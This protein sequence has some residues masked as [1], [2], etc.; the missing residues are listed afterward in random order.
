MKTYLNRNFLLTYGASFISLFGSKL[1]MMSYVAYI[2]AAKGSATLASIV[3][4]AD[5]ATSLVIGLFGTRYIDRCNAKHLLIGL[6][7]VA[8]V[9]TLSFLNFVSPD[10]YPFAIMVIVARA[11]LSHSVNSSRI[12]ALVQFFTKEETAAFSAVFNSSLF[13]A[14]ALAGAV[15]IYLLKFISF[16]T[17][18]YF[19][20]ATFLIAAGIFAFTRPNPQR[21]AE[22]LEASRG[23]VKAAYIAGAFRIIAGNTKLASAVF[24][25]ILSVTAFQ[26]TYEVLMTI[27]PQIWFG[28]GKSGTA[29]FFTCESVCVT[30]G[31]FL[32]QYL[33]NRG[34]ITEANQR[35]RNM[36]VVGVSALVYL[37]IPHL[38]HNVYLC[39]I[40][41][42]VMVVTVELIWTHQFKQMI[43]NIP[44]AKVAAVT[45]LQMAIGYSL[46]GVFAFV[47]SLGIDHLGV[48][49]AVYLNLLFGAV[50]VGGWE[51]LM[52]A[53]SAATDVEAGALA[54]E[55]A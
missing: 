14:A 13:M 42:N 47:F 49:S 46:M 8:A 5:W 35:R 17:V 12:K 31:A 38:T 32:Y 50:L 9:V 55:N 34:F 28:L 7:L 29:L 23:E 36:V 44:P 15:G 40:A 20:S 41:F 18:V 45:G 27:V 2:Y 10:K 3:F 11:L 30:A 48:G 51:L 52:R 33:A 54:R 4:A 39:L 6:N 26:A 24:Y 25:I 22:S 16:A 21:L 37:A 19:D 53:Q 43:A 1:L